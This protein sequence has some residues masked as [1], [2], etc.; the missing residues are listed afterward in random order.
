DVA[1]RVGVLTFRTKL[2]AFV[3]AAFVMGVG[4]AIQAQR[5]GYIEPS[6]SFTLDWTIE[7]VNA[8]IIGGVGTVFGPL[9]GSAIS[10][11]LSERLA[12]Y[13]EIHLT[14]LG[15]LLILIIRLGPNGLWGAA[16]QLARAGRRRLSERR[17]RQ[18]SAGAAGSVMAVAGAP[19]AGA[20]A[21]PGEVLAAAPAQP[22]RSGARDPRG[23][24]D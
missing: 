3:I 7:T 18:V 23:P 20:P 15:I 13:P 2:T 1:E 8:A 4:G 12:N 11:G 24:P 6:G 9:V 5:T 14:I 19:P 10:V 21:A 17:D 22:P 16:G